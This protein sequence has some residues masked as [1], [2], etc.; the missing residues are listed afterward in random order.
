MVAGALDRLR[1]RDEEAVVAAR[2]APA[3]ARPRAAGTAAARRRAAG[4]STS[5]TC[6][7]GG[8]V[9]EIELADRAMWSSTAES[10]PAI[11]SISSSLEPRRASRATCRTSSRS[12][13]GGIL[14]RA[15]TAR[16]AASDAR[17]GRPEDYAGGA[18]RT[19]LAR[20]AEAG[21]FVAH[22][23]PAPSRI[24]SA[25]AS[26][27]QAPAHR[28]RGVVGALEQ[29]DYGGDDA[30]RGRAARPRRRRRR[31]RGGALGDGRRCQRERGATAASTAARRS[32][33]SV[34]QASR[35]P[36]RRLVP[37]I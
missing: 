6:E 18:G 32:G 7:V 11:G 16:P 36:R 21:P 1:A 24:E 33:R 19:G 29:P 31:Q 34:L 26:A 37:P 25:P 28:A 23:Q 10:S 27:S 17:G 14:G 30:D 8:D 4:R 12:I 2:P 3:R 22:R 20:R 9:V 13:T 5:T 35:S 15:A